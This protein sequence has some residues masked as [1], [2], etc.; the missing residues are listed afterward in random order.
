MAEALNL[1]IGS[2]EVQ[3]ERSTTEIAVRPVARKR[4]VF[5][6]QLRDLS[7][8]RPTSRRGTVG[9]FEILRINAPERTVTRER[10][11]LATRAVAGNVTP[12]YYTSEDR[13]PFVPAGT[14]YLV[15]KPDATS[16]QRRALLAK[17]GLALV[18]NERR[19]G[20]T[21]LI[22]R[23]ES[24]AAEVAAALQEEGAVLVSEPDLITPRELMQ[25]QPPSDQLIGALWHLNNLGQRDGVTTGFKKGAD[26]RVIVAWNAMQSL[27]SANVAIGII[28]DGFDL[29][30][31]D[32]VGKALSPWDF[33]L[34][35][36][37]VHPRPDLEEQKFGDWHGTACAGVACGSA[38]A[39]FI[40]G[41][42]PMSP[43]IPV[44]F[45]PDL[46]PDEIVRCFDHMTDKG[47]GSSAAVGAR[48]L[49][50]IRCPHGSP[51]PS[52]AVL[53]MDALERAR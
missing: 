1:R 18:R 21:G 27:G 3:L 50:V 11:E 30:H 16:E 5:E 44:R 25:F 10:N 48:P 32:L 52:R 6:N 15:F 39:G 29:S 36:P 40:V 13:V 45:G 24:D 23:T 7:E 49:G 9:G 31:P 47:A 26:A 22:G 2:R 28:D 12:V 53:R 46:V 20:F 51:K 14:I 4:V 41:A 33:Y 17:Y 37:D 38:G 34:G 43:V 19:E 8:R 42:A 35:S